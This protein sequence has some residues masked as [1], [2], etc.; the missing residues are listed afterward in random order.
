MGLNTFTGS[1]PADFQKL[2]LLEVWHL[3]GN[4]LTG[5]IPDKFQYVSRLSDFQLQNNKFDGTIPDTLGFLSDLSKL[6]AEREI[7]GS[8][9]WELIAKILR[10]LTIPS[11]PF[12]ISSGLL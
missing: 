9:K 10:N 2:T 12:C 6:L 1:I 5:S 3:D 8:G 11:S 7:D 4:Q